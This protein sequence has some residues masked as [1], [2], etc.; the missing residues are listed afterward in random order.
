MISLIAAFVA[1]IGIGTGPIGIAVAAAGAFVASA[2]L[3]KILVIGGAAVAVVTIVGLV[4][5]KGDVETDLETAKGDAARAIAAAHAH[6]RLPAE[7]IAERNAEAIDQIQ[8]LHAEQLAGARAE[9][10]R[11]RLARQQLADRKGEIRRDPDAATPVS[12]PVQRYLDRLRE[13]RAAAGTAPRRGPGDPPGARAPA[14]KPPVVP[15]RAVVAGGRGG[16]ALGVPA[17]GRGSAPRG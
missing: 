17:V 9:I 7:A 13:R 6:A 12:P 14:A 4:I 3:R 5:A 1:S 2:G 11:E 15:R 10:D 16:A 8:A